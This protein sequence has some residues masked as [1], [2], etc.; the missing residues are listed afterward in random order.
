MSG[1]EDLLSGFSQSFGATVKETKDKK[2]QEALQREHMQMQRDQF[3]QSLQLQRE[4]LA[5]RKETRRL[6]MELRQRAEDRADED[7]GFKRSQFSLW[8]KTVGSDA[9]VQDWLSGIGLNRRGK[10]AEVQ[11]KEA[12][13][14]DLEGLKAY[15]QKKRDLEG[16]MG[17]LALRGADINNDKNAAET[18]RIQNE[19]AEYEKDKPLRELRRE[20]LSSQAKAEMELN[21]SP[22]AI[23]RQKRAQNRAEVG[24]Q[25][26]LVDA[27]REIEKDARNHGIKLAELNIQHLHATLPVLKDLI[28]GFNGN[29]DAA[30][31]AF[32]GML[33]ADQVLA[34]NPGTGLQMTREDPS[35]AND[36]MSAWDAIYNIDKL[37][38][39]EAQA[40]I[41]N[42]VNR[43]IPRFQ[44]EPRGV[45][46]KNPFT[47][48][49]S[50]VP[51]S[52]P[53]Q[54]ERPLLDRVREKMGKGKGSAGAAP[55][56]AMLG[57]DISK[58]NAA[59]IMAQRGQRLISAGKES[60]VPDNNKLP[61]DIKDAADLFDTW[62]DSNPRA[63]LLLSKFVDRFGNEDTKVD[64]S[65]Y[66]W[67]KKWLAT[68]V[69]KRAKVEGRDLEGAL[70]KAIMSA[71]KIV[72]GQKPGYWRTDEKPP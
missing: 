31:E 61:S 19:L 40:R 20:L 65:S 72:A 49:E 48:E 2:R 41:R 32:G 36:H 25:L 51:G 47:G 10:T 3:S 64:Q 12:E 38:P 24:D 11:L 70:S 59:E 22:S 56:K 39:A 37:D 15:T 66:E 23:E 28:A 13:V 35:I 71:E 18:E 1:L 45:T 8:E 58:E 62:A 42:Y 6:E 60:F 9:G 68:E 27:L 57:K 50:S 33:V 26:K 46:E 52:A 4:D 17:D 14:E 34:G 53:Q 43:V 63:E 69:A 7:Q 67:M 44:Q 30:V 16:R 5:D 29:V 54:D 55:L 21:Y